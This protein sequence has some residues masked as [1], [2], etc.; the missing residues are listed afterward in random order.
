MAGGRGN[1]N[2]MYDHDRYGDRDRDDRRGGRDR[3]GRHNRRDMDRDRDHDDQNGGMASRFQSLDEVI[4]QVRPQNPP[5]LL[6]VLLIKTN[7][8]L[9]G[10]I[11][12]DMWRFLG[13][14]SPKNWT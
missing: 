10:Q 5:R 13:F 14:H 4:G 3:R 11:L 9:K 12:C 6:T 7:W 1:G 2:G 8:Q